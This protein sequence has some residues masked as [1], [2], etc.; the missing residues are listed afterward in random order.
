MINRQ[1]VHDNVICTLNPAGQGMCNGDSGGS[2]VAG[3]FVIGVPS[4]V[5]PC[6]QGFPD[7]YAR[8]SSHN[9]WI[10]QNIGG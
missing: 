3:N 8:V 4:W 2:L 6:G 7:A 9:A 1:F 10:L 5:I